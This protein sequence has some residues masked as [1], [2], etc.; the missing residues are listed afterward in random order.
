MEGLP[1]LDAAD[2]APT[3]ED[4]GIVRTKRFPM[5]P[6]SVDEAITK[7]DLLSHTFFLFHNIETDLYSVVYRREDGDYGL[8][9]AT[10]A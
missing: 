1:E 8:I 3:V 9:E 4:G 5:R 10:P 2:D 7:M 6:M